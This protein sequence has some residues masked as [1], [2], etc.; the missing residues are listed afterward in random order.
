M[1]LVLL[2]IDVSEQD[3]A[4]IASG[5]WEGVLLVLPKHDYELLQQA[6]DISQLDEDISIAEWII[7]DALLR[8]RE[9]V[10]EERALDLDPGDVIV[11]GI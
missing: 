4:V 6:R 9:T 10:L 1:P 5:D 8:A 2:D 3:A 7:G 11:P